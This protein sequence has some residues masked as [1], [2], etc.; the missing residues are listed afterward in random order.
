MPELSFELGPGKKDSPLTSIALQTDVHPD[1][2]DGPF[3]GSARVLFAR[4]N[5]VARANG[6]NG[7]AHW[8]A[9]RVASPRSWPTI[10]STAASAWGSG[11]KSGGAERPSFEATRLPLPFIRS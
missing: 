2:R 3:S 8:L 9:A 7:A 11:C 1:A 4:L 10:N 6:D 5:P